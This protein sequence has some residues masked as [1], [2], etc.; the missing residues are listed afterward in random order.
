MTDLRTALLFTMEL[1]IGTRRDI[2]Q[3]PYGLRRIVEVAGGRFVGEELR[4]EVL[5]VAGDW[6]LR[7]ADGVMMID[8]RLTLRTQ[9]EHLVYMSYRGM[10]HGPEWVME[11]LAKGERVDPSEYYFRTTPYFE[12][13]SDKYSWLNRIVTVGVGRREAKG[14]VYDV[15]QVL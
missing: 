5:P 10:Q 13:A 4:G 11:R 8:V 6:L 12:T 9:D 1:D 14:P 15:F 7:R 3:T 2:G